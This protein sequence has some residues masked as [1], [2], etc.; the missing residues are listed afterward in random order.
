MTQAFLAAE[1]GVKHTTVGRWVR[2]SIPDLGHC[3]AI[4]LF[5]H[6]DPA[7]VIRLTGKQGMIE[8]YR[9]LRAEAQI[10]E[11]QSTDSTLTDEQIEAIRKV[12]DIIQFGG[13]VWEALRMNIN[14]FWE[15]AKSHKRKPH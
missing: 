7:E 5:F 4:A 10:Q 15:H 11:I 2:G 3:I 1:L 12:K 8:T 9:K 14:V 6:R 13:H